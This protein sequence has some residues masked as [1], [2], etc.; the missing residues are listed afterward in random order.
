MSR[1]AASAEGRA[2]SFWM[3]VVAGSG[4][5]CAG[6]LG[7]SSGGFEVCM[8]IVEEG[9]GEKRSWKSP[10]AVWS[11]AGTLQ[12]VK[13]GRRKVWRSFGRVHI[14][15]D[16]I[17]SVF[18]AEAEFLAF[19]KEVGVE[20]EVRLGAGVVSILDAVAE[21]E[22][23]DFDG[24]AGKETTVVR[25]AMSAGMWAVGDACGRVS[26]RRGMS[27]ICARERALGGRLRRYCGKET[28]CEG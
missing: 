28:D 6:A 9:G 25:W 2:R 15:C 26:S 11:M 16:D 23:F 3:V 12:G 18:V 21:L 7:V 22:L 24:V 27:R 19:L 4:I 13:R 17:A 8:F 10:S 20:A 14:G 1:E 5:S